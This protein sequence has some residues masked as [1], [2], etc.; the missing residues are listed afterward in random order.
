MTVKNIWTMN[1]IMACPH[2]AVVSHCGAVR[3]ACLAAR[4]LADRS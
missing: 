3:M 4:S 1:W 2:G